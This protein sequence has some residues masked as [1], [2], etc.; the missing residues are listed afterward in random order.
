MSVGGEYKWSFYRKRLVTYMYDLVPICP[1]ARADEHKRTDSVNT[2][3]EVTRIRCWSLWYT[4]PTDWT[5]RVRSIWPGIGGVK[6]GLDAGVYGI[7]APLMWT[8]RV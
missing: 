8:L 6:G 3:G 2:F 7:P 5:R 4:I 1:C